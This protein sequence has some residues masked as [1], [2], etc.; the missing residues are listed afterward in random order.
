MDTQFNVIMDDK[1]TFI[2][3]LLHYFITEKNYT[4]I[5]LQGAEEEI[6]QEAGDRHAVHGQLHHGRQDH[7]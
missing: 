5:I 4:P 6:P 1:N 7:L 3:K 2:M